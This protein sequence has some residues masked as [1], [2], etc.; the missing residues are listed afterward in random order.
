MDIFLR[1][2]L[3]GI[4]S[5]SV[6]A[7]ASTGLVL[8]YKISGVLNLGYGSLALFTGFV[9]WNFA[10]EWGWPP[11][12]AALIVVLVVAPAIG[13]FLDTQ[14]FRRIEGQPPVIGIIATVGLFVLLLG[15]VQFIWKGATRIPPS[16]FPSGTVPLPGGA[17]IGVEQLGIIAVAAA[18]AGLLAAL[19]RFTRIGVAF[20]AVVDNRPVAGLMAINTPFVSGMAWA[21]GTS[22]A[23]LTGILLGP[24]LFLDPLTFPPFII[25]FV[26]GAAIV[27]YMRSLPLAYVGG[28]AIG[29]AEALII[30]YGSGNALLA[31]LRT[32]LPFLF[33]TVL[34]L[35]APKAVRIAGL[36]ASFVVR[37]R[38]IAGQASAL[39]RN[40]A[41][42]VAFG[43]LALAPVLTGGSIS[44]TIALTIGVT[45]AIVFLSLV[46]L[47][48][49]SGQI[50]LGQTAF[51][52]IA[53][54][55]AGHL[56]A[57]AGLSMWIA[58]PIGALA[59]VPAGA[60]IGIVA[61]RLHGLF[62]A[63]MTL[64][65]AF[66]AQ[67]L[68]FDKPG[69]SGGE[70]GVPVPRP[71]GFADETAFYYL[72]LAILVACALLAVN[73]RSGRTGR[74]LA[75]MR[76][77]ETASRSLG[78]NVFKYKVFIF[79]LSAFIAGLGGILNSM[80]LQQANVRT[81]APFFSLIYMTV[82]VVGGIFHI[83]G[84]IVIGLFF[85]LYNK[86]LP[87]KVFGDIQ[88]ILFGLGATLALAQNPE[89]MFG[90]LRRGAAAIRRAF[91]RRPSPEAAPVAGGQE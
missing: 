85:G 44:W 59:A 26:L 89:G 87:F 32:A 56:A 83:G 35:A 79:G 25:A 14:L 65:F 30:Q 88:L 38:E 90:E 45:N 49:Y 29:V 46:I 63:L 81:F 60:L 16:L 5:G 71:P 50:S 82:A 78:I 68:F 57:D 12:L 40:G 53:T 24:Q 39:A 80:I 69:I 19:L 6:Y 74:V 73:L 48:G 66:M 67:G 58:L 36:G 51:M 23:A 75:A 91:S 86:I 10:V 13:I 18:S 27:G 42:V 11:W 61:V 8:T 1:T 43:L 54:F 62:L 4:A 64:A 17:N 52:G 47:T 41:G 15:F 22:F 21:L 9:Y 7:L 28:I 76:D 20:R 34:V 55:S 84:A 3:L 70:G 33:I 31:N 2:L 72:A 37:T 77:S